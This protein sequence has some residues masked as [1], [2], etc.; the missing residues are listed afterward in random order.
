MVDV[1]SPDDR[2]TADDDADAVVADIDAAMDLG[3]SGVPFFVVGGRY[4]V[5]GAQPTD[6]FARVLQQAWEESRPT[7]AVVAGGDA[8]ACGVDGSC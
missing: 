8:D 6:V 3:V 4:A 2:I 5:S 1:I 7:V